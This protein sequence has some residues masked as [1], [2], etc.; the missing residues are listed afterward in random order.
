MANPS[1]E[2]TCLQRLREALS[3]VRM[4]ERSYRAAR[5]A[6]LLR[7]SAETESR[8]TVSVLE[9]ELRA[10]KTSKA[11]RV[12]V[13]LGD[14]FRDPRLIIGWPRKGVRAVRRRFF[15]C[16]AVERVT[17]PHQVKAVEVN[18]ADSLAPL[19]GEIVWL[20]E[21]P[22]F[23]AEV[24]ELRMALVA[25][26][27]TTDSLE[28]ECN[29]ISLD[30]ANWAQQILQFEPHVLFVE[31]AWVGLNGEWQGKVSGA[32]EEICSL[33]MSCRSAG[34]PTVFWN[35][36]D[37]LHFEAFVLVA[38]LFDHV[39]TTDADSIPA[40]RRKLGH[41]RVGVLPFAVQ[42]RLHHPFMDVD[43]RRLE[44]SFFAG[45]WYGNLSER[46]RDF[47]ELAEALALIGPFSIY[48]RNDGKGAAGRQY[49]ADYR[50][51]LH[52]AVSYD[53]TPKLYRSYRIGLS[54][55]TIK[56]SSTMFAR[57]ALELICT[58]TSVYSNYSRGIKTLL[59]D[60]VLASDD[61]QEIFDWAWSELRDPDSKVNRSRRLAAMRKVLAEH[62]WSARLQSVLATVTDHP[63]ESEQGSRDVVVI[64]R[65]SSVNELDKLLA[66]AATQKGIK[67][68]LYV[69]AD[70]VIE[71]PENVGRLSS[72]DL[73][74]VVPV[75]FGNRLVAAWD[76]RDTYGAYY[77]TDLVDCLHFG[78]GEIIGKA[79]FERGDGTISGEGLEYRKVSSLA[80][81]RSLAPATYW[82]YT[83]S[84]VLSGI[85]TGG[86]Y[87]SGLLSADR[88]SY[89]ETASLGDSA[90]DD[91]IDTGVSMSVLNR[92]LNESGTANTGNGRSA[93]CIS[94]GAL[95]DLFRDGVV[96]PQT[97]VAHRNGA[98][99]LVSKLEERR[100]AALF[101][102]PF[103]I[104]GG[105]AAV[106]TVPLC[107]Q[108]EPSNNFDVY[109][110]GLSGVAGSYSAINR[111]RLFPGVTRLIPVDANVGALRL[112]ITVRGPYVGYWQGI[113]VGDSTPNPMVLPGEGRILVVVNGYP[114]AGDLYR[115]AFVHRRV[116][117]YMDRGIGVDVVWVTSQRPRESYEHDGVRVDV[118]DSFTLRET[119]AHSAHTAIAVHFL[120]EEIWEGLKNAAERIRTVVWI[121]GADI[122][123]Y[124]RRLFNYKSERERNV[125]RQLSDRRLLF[126]RTIFGLVSANL[127]FVFVSK[128]LLVQAQEDVG[129]GPRK[130]S[131]SVVHNPI[132]TDR[133]AFN[134]KR[135]EDRFNVL[136]IRPHASRIYANDLLAGAIV[137]LSQEPEFGSMRFTLVGDG[138][139]WEENFDSLK[140]FENV[141]LVRGF[142]GAAD[143]ARFHAEHG[144]FLAPTRGD[145]QGVSR[146]EAMSSGLV[147]VTNPAGAVPEFVDES[148]GV[149]CSE[150]SA[151]ELAQGY[152]SLVRDPS[153]FVKL[154]AGAAARVRGQSSSDMI[155]DSEVQIL[156]ISHLVRIF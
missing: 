106:G 64:A 45:A 76:A 151:E 69:F 23:P 42:P 146:D 117:A 32:S 54:L 68:A 71:V 153:R 130:G 107:L 46:S 40:Y 62:T 144:V 113:S 28:L 52:P 8:E 143:I 10:V 149:L 27:F 131:F 95:V 92:Y 85:G 98:M 97:S 96:P 6:L 70:K 120:D 51:Y 104:E 63:P 49:P 94:G 100:E 82:T 138:A 142:V 19:S 81:R 114:R 9:A 86:F 135:M 109:I 116:R 24:K 88:M 75:L 38:S 111:N 121:H 147:P 83:L 150:E 1:D 122:Q 87:G 12:A 141:S 67:V 34:I 105:G 61:G 78:Q 4:A 35:K 148:S 139:L 13:L 43:E 93:A 39:F 124:T 156:G 18:F 66:M 48:D 112:A 145:T 126:W 50:K 152:L 57:R 80:W 2:A 25:D 119:L 89:L 53:M 60:L 11:Y 136:S 115:N 55:N 128:N 133:F 102:A 91:R 154:S 36:E 3:R 21:P 90:P 77:L 31:S 140:A 17:V 5:D 127:H 56:Q 16:D 47:Q 29:T 59:G 132:D 22:D 123:S 137:R 37:P 58:N 41:G 79:C 30:P 118:C 101:S 110:D 15:A 65:A 74:T 108:A 26:R 155:I 129:I 14:A 99:E 20:P 7:E 72:E 44:G 103:V 84:E 134:Q 33:V 73:E 125:A